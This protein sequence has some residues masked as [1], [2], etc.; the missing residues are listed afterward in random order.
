[1]KEDR[2]V[3]STRVLNAPR[4][5]VFRAFSDPKH[6]S[7]WWGPKGFRN[8]FHAFDLRPGGHWRVT[9]HGPE[10]TDYKNEYVLLEVTEPERIGSLS[11]IPTRS[12][13]FS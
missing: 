5:V 12:T 11:V 10:G 1:M 8:T 9:M 13:T 3:V 7:Q 2:E 6:L 4:E